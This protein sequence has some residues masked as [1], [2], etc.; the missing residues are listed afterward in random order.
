MFIRAGNMKKA[1]ASKRRTGILCAAVLSVALTGCDDQKNVGGQAPHGSSAAP[2]YQHDLA[3]LRPLAAADIAKAQQQLAALNYQPGPVDGVMGHKT[4]I[5]IKHFQVDEE[6]EVDGELTPAVLALLKK[7]T[8]K[9]HS[10]LNPTG[11]PEETPGAPDPGPKPLNT[12]GPSY[13]V[14]DTYVYSDGRVETVSRVG[15]ERTLWET[16]DGSVYTAYRNFILPPISWKSDTGRGENQVQ[17]PAGPNWPP[18]TT[19]EVVFS[20]GSK[21]GDGSV[22]APKSW[23]GKWRCVTRGDSPV[24]AL[25]GL[26]DAVI[27]ECQRANPEPGTWKKRRWYYVPEIG[28]YV[29]RVDMIHGTERKTTVDLVAVRPGRKGWPP[30]ARGGLDWAIQGALDSGDYKNIV[31]WRSSAVGAMFSIRLMGNVA[32]SDKA[33]C[34]RYSIKR[35]SPDQIRLFPAIACKTPTGERWLTPG[36]DSGSISPRAL[37]R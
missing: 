27:I 2:E 25:A 23:S 4:S 14:G 8:R 37:K 29:R 7:R 22:D 32:G 3:A 35:T 16:G 19:S 1:W 28:H 33:D 24:E 17:S 18:A 26:F 10:S 21:A 20:V 36:V 31:E 30:A 34:Q 13:E 11:K 12:A 5:A 6:L 9:R 15:P